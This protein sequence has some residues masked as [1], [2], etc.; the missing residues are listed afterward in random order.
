MPLNPL[1]TTFAPGQNSQGAKAFPEGVVFG[2]AIS[3]TQGIVAGGY[4]PSLTVQ[5]AAGAGASVGSQVGTDQAGSFVL[6]AGS[7]STAGGSQVVLTFA[8]PLPSTPVSVNVTAGNTTSSATTNVSAGAISVSK[9][10]FTVYSS[11]P[12]ANATYLISY[13]V[14]RAP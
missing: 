2:G 4:K 12:A 13:Q 6:T 8:T 11:A 7:A 10:G 1:P 5:T 3:T 14:F 9:S